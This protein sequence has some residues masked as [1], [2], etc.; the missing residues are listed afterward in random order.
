MFDPI[1]S[2]SPLKAFV[3]EFD[4]G[5]AAAKAPQGSPPRELHSA[6][7]LRNPGVSKIA[8]EVPDLGLQLLG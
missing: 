7:G 3:L 8:R 5:V 6:G 4:R 1:I 2:F